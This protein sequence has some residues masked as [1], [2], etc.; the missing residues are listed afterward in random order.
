MIPSND[1]K[2]IF[3]EIEDDDVWSGIFYF[4][5]HP[6]NPNVERPKAEDGPRG[7]R[8]GALAFLIRNDGLLATCAHVATNASD[9]GGRFL[10]HGFGASLTFR[11]A[12]VPVKVEASLLREG[13]SGPSVERWRTR[14]RDEDWGADICFFKLQLET[15]TSFEYNAGETPIVGDPRSALIEH[16]R[17]LPLGSP[18]YPVA[19]DEPL[20]AHQV[21][22]SPAGFP[23]NSSSVAHFRAAEPNLS[24]GTVTVASPD[25]A[26]GDSGGPLWDSTRRRVVAMVRSGRGHLKDR[27]FAAD[28]RTIAALSGVPIRIDAQ[29]ERLISGLDEIAQA[30]SVMRHF[31]ILQDWM[32]SSYVELRIAT[33]QPAADIVAD[34]IKVAPRPATIGV[35]EY[36]QRHGGCLLLG[37]AGAGK[38][39]F[40]SHLS[41]HLL[42][43]EVF[44]RGKRL[45]PLNYHASD[46]KE[47]GLDL[48]E[49]IEES[50]RRA[51]S[52]FKMM[53]SL[54]EVLSINDLSLIVLIDG[55]DEIQTGPRTK[56]LR[57]VTERVVGSLKPMANKNDLHT[58]EFLF[59][60]ATRPGDDVKLSPEGHGLGLM[61]VA[62]LQPLNKDE[63]TQIVSS[64]IDSEEDRASVSELI[65]VLS[66]A[67][68]GPTPLQLGVALNFVTAGGLQPELPVRPI[69]LNFRLIDHLISLGVEE[70]RKHRENDPIPR[71][72]GMQ[73]LSE[74]LRE[75]LQVL[76]E[77]F[78]AGATT[79]EENCMM[80]NFVIASRTDCAPEVRDFLRTETKLLGAI[81]RPVERADGR[82][83]LVWPHRTIPEALAA[84]Y[85]KRHAEDYVA[86]FGSFQRLLRE[87]SEAFELQVLS[88]IDGTRDD[89]MDLASKLVAFKL[90]KSHMQTETTWYALR[91]L[92][93]GLN[94]REDVFS[95]LVLILLKLLFIDFQDRR[96]N[97]T[98]AMKCSSFFSSASAPSPIAVA[99]LPSVQR[100][101]ISHLNRTLEI[102][103]RGT[104]AARLTKAEAKVIDRLS[105]WGQLTV[106]VV[107][108]DPSQGYRQPQGGGMPMQ[109]TGAQEPITL[110]NPDD[111]TL[112]R[113]VYHL[114]RDPL[115]FTNAFN[116]FLSKAG[117]GRDP[118]ECLKSFV[119]LWDQ[120]F[121]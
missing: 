61:Q 55:L 84:E 43:H 116:A 14:L 33:P 1:H 85:H 59:V 97:N 101:L 80:A 95:R 36:A 105:L 86:T 77:N 112:R 31:P 19:C 34:K 37:G 50:V 76:G 69:D 25:I 51:G 110:W 15:A 96:L 65:E 23:R 12:K 89:G 98:F 7:G 49:M 88:Q 73:F 20:R 66:W 24:G 42:D 90:D 8:V 83:E 79:L 111:D 117:E 57:Q 102:R 54:N 121:G 56:L 46:F 28:A 29:A 48:R 104:G 17:V 74:N 94:L 81:L 113:T 87:R 30:K 114:A 52:D 5:S 16:A 72:A 62:E 2:R 92:A 64:R 93:C 9:V 91:V 35:L 32:Q 13:W 4:E 70:D 6:R 45:L 10:C 99:S 44:H 109:I 108:T 120:Q 53:R 58:D 78:I 21:T 82:T 75:L 71:A 100:H 39:R 27:E 63:V 68:D 11:S 106:S 18:N 41:R 67:Q 107:G 40:L 119:A 115:A 118:Q 47:S 22:Y 38:S 3:S 60:V 103:A 26:S